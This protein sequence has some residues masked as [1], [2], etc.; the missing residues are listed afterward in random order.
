[1]IEERCM[2]ERSAKGSASF[3]T[4]GTEGSFP[5]Q[6]AVHTLAS[7][8]EPRLQQ[9]AD[10]TMQTGTI[11]H[12]RLKFLSYLLTVDV[13][14]QGKICAHENALSCGEQH[15]ICLLDELN[16]RCIAVSHKCV[17][18]EQALHHQSPRG[19]RLG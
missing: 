11:C 8:T 14:E 15:R 2:M 13:C 18:L 4:P 3:N 5:L 9:G 1:M 10:G 6:I 12:H 19:P 16:A 7:F 17:I